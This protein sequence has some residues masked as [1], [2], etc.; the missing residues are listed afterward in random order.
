MERHKGTLHIAKKIG[1]KRIAVITMALPSMLPR[2]LATREWAKK[3]GLKVVLWERYPLPDPLFRLLPFRE[4]VRL[5]RFSW[6]YLSGRHRPRTEL[7]NSGQ[8]D[9]AK[10]Q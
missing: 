5:A 9:K 2:F 6:Q 10:C 1:I 4:R 3:L 8:A 7:R